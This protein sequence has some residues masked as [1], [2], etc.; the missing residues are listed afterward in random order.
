[1][2]LGAEGGVKG[3]GLRRAAVVNLASGLVLAALVGSMAAP[4]VGA[5]SAKTAESAPAAIIQVTVEDGLLSAELRDAPLVDALRAVGEQAG[6]EVVVR[7]EA[8]VLVTQ[9]LAGVPVEEGVRRLLEDAGSWSLVHAPAGDGAAPR[10]AEVRLYG[11]DRRP[12]A[13]WA[14]AEVADGGKPAQADREV[15]EPDDP[16]I[17]LQEIA[18]E[19]T[20]AH[21]PELRAALD[22]EDTAGRRLAAIALG[23]AGGEGARQA[24]AGALADADDVVRL[25]AVQALGRMRSAEA[26]LAIRAV[27]LDDP[28]AEVRRFAVSV[29]ARRPDPSALDALHAAK[30]DPDAGVRRAIGHALRRVTSLR[31]HDP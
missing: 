1:M 10:L 29:L 9:S 13:A 14:A 8:G 23:R 20:A 27:L 12:G 24:L 5:D 25:R 19:P 18:R 2:S 6:F 15:S 17:R 21:L 30:F 7:G 3:R 26:S 28:A 16:L 22:A 31:A 4:G 11:G